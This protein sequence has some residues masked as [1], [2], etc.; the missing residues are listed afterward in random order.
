MT[1]KIVKWILFAVLFSLLTLLIV[2]Y[3][4]LA[5][6]P[7]WLLFDELAAIILFIVALIVIP[8]NLKLLRVG[9]ILA[10]TVITIVTFVLAKPSV[11]RVKAVNDKNP[12]KTE[13]LTLANGK[14]QGVY[15][16]NKTVEV[17]AGIPYAK[18]PVGDLR[19]KE[20]QDVENWEGIRGCSTFAPK[21]MQ[22]K[23]S[24]VFNTIKDRYKILT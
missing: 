8:K 1:K 2:F 15:N 18:A 19:W 11:E 21:S 20:P 16:S 7:M 3:L 12:E 4:D 6:G 23:E 10:F 13:V 17:Y 5:N 24:G 14:V 9:A 22:A